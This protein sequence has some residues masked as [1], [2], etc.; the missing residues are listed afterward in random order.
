MRGAAL[1]KFMQSILCL[2]RDALIA[3][4]SGLFLE[5]QSLEG[6]LSELQEVQKGMIREYQ[7][8][9][10]SLEKAEADRDALIRQNQ[11]LTGVTTLRTND[12]F[13]RSTEKTEEILKRAVSREDAGQ[14][15]ENPV[16]EDAE[17][18]ETSEE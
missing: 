2:D 12:L 11:R 17:D 4:A 5:K 10:N 18:V 13:G 8:L 6:K 16:D 1:E 3:T 9:K 15:P 7:A 14:N